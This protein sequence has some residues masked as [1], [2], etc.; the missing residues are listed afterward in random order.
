MRGGK[1]GTQTSAPSRKPNQKPPKVRSCTSAPSRSPWTAAS[2]MQPDDQEVDPVHRSEG[3]QRCTRKRCPATIVGAPCDLLSACHGGARRAGWR[4]PALLAAVARAASGC[5]RQLASSSHPVLGPQG[6]PPGRRAA[7]AGGHRRARRLSCAPP[8]GAGRSA[9]RGPMRRRAGPRVI[10]A[11][12]DGGLKWR[13]RGGG[14]I[15]QLSG[16][17]CPTPRTAWPWAP[18]AP[19]SRERGRWQ[20]QTAA[21]SGRRSAPAGALNM[22]GSVHSVTACVM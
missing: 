13:H 6:H 22:P 3:S 12:K 10:I 20:R 8:S 18:P 16:I 21:P 9:S 5:A 4:L 19:R 15:P 14:G 17:S 1:R 11:T 7:G 2:S